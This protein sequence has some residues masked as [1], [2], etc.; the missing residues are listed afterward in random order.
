MGGRKRILGGIHGLEFVAPKPPIRPKRYIRRWSCGGRDAL[1]AFRCM[2]CCCT[3]ID[4]LALSDERVELN[5]AGQAE[6]KLKTRW[7]CR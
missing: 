3:V 5:A 1:L 6:P 4:W 7:T 2:R